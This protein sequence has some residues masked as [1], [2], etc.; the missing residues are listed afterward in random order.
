MGD[1]RQRGSHFA[2]VNPD[3]RLVQLVPPGVKLRDLWAATTHRLWTMGN[4][5]ASPSCY[6]AGVGPRVDVPP[7]THIP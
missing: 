6:E 5:C 7:L 3:N 4:K 1:G 2:N